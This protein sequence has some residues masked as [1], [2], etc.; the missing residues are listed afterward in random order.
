MKSNN[1]K[2]KEETHGKAISKGDTPNI[3]TVPV[4]LPEEKSQGKDPSKI[5]AESPNKES[6]RELEASDIPKAQVGVPEVKIE[7]P[8]MEL[9]KQED[10]PISDQPDKEEEEI[11]PTTIKDLYHCMKKME[12]RLEKRLNIVHMD[13]GSQLGYIAELSMRNTVA[14]LNGNKYA[15]SSCPGN[16]YDIIE[17][18]HENVSLSSIREMLS[19]IFDDIKVMCESTHIFEEQ[20]SRYTRFQFSQ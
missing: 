17:F 1:S 16:C 9:A 6:S 18:L 3:S 19:M 2:T 11:E 14:T 7:P 10:N 15:Q 4:T 20:T 12:S 13:L 5:D 8:K